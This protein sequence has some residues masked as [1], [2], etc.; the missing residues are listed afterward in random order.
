MDK[1]LIEFLLKIQTRKRM[2]DT[3]FAAFIGVSL[4]DWSRVKN[5]KRKISDGFKLSVLENLIDYRDEILRIIAP[6]KRK[7]KTIVP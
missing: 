5:E 7:I 4:P 6:R 2:N 3:E 1:K